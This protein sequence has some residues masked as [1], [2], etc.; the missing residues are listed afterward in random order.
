[1]KLLKIA[2][3]KRFLPDWVEGAAL[4]IYESTHVVSSHDN[5]LR[6]S[7]HH[8]NKFLQ[9]QI[10]VLGT[11]HSEHYYYIA[12]KTHLSIIMHILREYVI[13]IKKKQSPYLYLL[14]LMS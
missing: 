8:E 6:S 11:R 7:L 2:R 14:L 3:S 12:D 4:M 5:T 1:M 10:H 13:V 9:C